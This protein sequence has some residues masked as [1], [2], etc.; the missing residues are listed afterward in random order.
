MT[1]PRPEGTWQSLWQSQPPSERAMS[2]EEVREEARHLERRV[3]RRNRREYIAA[4]V[5]VVGYGWILWRAPSAAIR[6]GA[7]LIIAAT[8]FICYQL[9]VHGSAASLQADLGIKS[10][11]D[12]YRVQLE[13]QRELLHGMWRWCLLPFV[14][15]LL[16]LLIGQALAQPARVSFVVTY[17]VLV[18]ILGVGLHAV[19]RRVA[20]RLQRALDRLKDNA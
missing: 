9:R 5:V 4:V 19:N 1:D 15:G 13:R 6:V 10:S 17:G 11:L 18:L 14:P 20:A 8:I 2:I 7:G 16:V 12:F 3:A